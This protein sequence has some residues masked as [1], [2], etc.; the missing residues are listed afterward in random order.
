[1][2]LQKE[3]KKKV[4]SEEMLNENDLHKKN[5]ILYITPGEVLSRPRR[6]HP[7]TF[8]SVEIFK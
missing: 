5:A 2:N 6:E 1:L 7:V 8:S 4:F 3:R